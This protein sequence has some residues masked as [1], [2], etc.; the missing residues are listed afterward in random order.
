M[1]LRV[2]GN[3]EGTGNETE[4]QKPTVPSFLIIV[5]I[6]QVKGDS[7]EDKA[8][9]L[10]TIKLKFPGYIA[11][12]INGKTWYAPRGDRAVQ[13]AE[14]IDSALSGKLIGRT[15]LPDDRD[16]N[17]NHKRQK[18]LSHGMTL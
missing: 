7:H 15:N 12:R 4:T 9:A 3:T 17:I 6:P 13:N 10:P 18:C 5:P 11:Y 14:W 1:V 2:N 8:H 16:I